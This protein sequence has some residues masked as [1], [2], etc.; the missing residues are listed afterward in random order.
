MEAG[1]GGGNEPSVPSSAHRLSAKD[2]TFWEKTLKKPKNRWCQFDKEK[3][4]LT[5]I[6]CQSVAG[7]TSDFGTEGVRLP[8]SK[9]GCV[10]A[11]RT[12]GNH[13]KSRGHVTA[14]GLPALQR[15]AAQGQEKTDI[16]P[17]QATRRDC[18]W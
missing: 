10:I 5:C 8:I 17:P 1:E 12:L 18:A 9:R 15:G 7:D 4:L 16:S 14:A 6:I 13:S 3:Q 2:I 11:G